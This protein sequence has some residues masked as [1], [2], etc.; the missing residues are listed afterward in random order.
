MYIYKYILT[1]KKK[2]QSILVS[3]CKFQATVKLKK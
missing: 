2:I 3:C 1:L